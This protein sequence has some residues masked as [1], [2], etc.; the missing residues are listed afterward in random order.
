SAPARGPDPRALPRRD[1]VEHVPRAL[2]PRR[3]PG[4]AHEA[5]AP[6]GA[7]PRA[8]PRAP[9]QPRA[10]PRRRAE[11]VAL[12]RRRGPRA[13][14]APR[15]RGR[16]VAAGLARLVPPLGHGGG[17]GPPVL[18]RGPGRRPGGPPAAR[19]PRLR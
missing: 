2:L 13:G 1:R 10:R 7:L 16:R 12:R 9:W 15:G 17:R 19:G 6:A 11:D 5:V 8:G 18:P 14:A 4:L 3:E